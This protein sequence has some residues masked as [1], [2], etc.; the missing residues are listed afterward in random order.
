MGADLTERL[1]CRHP[2]PGYAPDLFGKLLAMLTRSPIAVVRLIA[3]DFTSVA[4]R[5]SNKPLSWD[6]GTAYEIMKLL[7][8][9]SPERLASLA[10]A[11]DKL[12]STMGLD[13]TTNGRSSEVEF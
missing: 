5:A 8:Y 12:Y 2:A 3:P 7:D 6:N 1:F 9:L 4:L 11:I 10:S 13:I